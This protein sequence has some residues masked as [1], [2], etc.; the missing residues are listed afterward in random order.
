MSTGAEAGALPLA[1][2]SLPAGAAAPP[3]RRAG[4]G[5]ARLRAAGL[6]LLIPAGLG[7]VWHLATVGR[8]YSLI[9]PPAE[10]WTELRD[11]AFGGI[12]DDAFSGTL[13]AHL[14]ASLARVYG[15]F[16][17]AAAAALPLGL[18]I[19]RV[20]V[21]RALLDP[22]LQILRP[23]PVTAWLPLAMILFGLGP[24]SAY[25]LVFLGAFYPILVNTV[26]GVRSVE[27]RLFEAAAM[28]GCT[29]TAQF[30]RVVLPA[31]LP[32]IFTGLRLGLGFAWVVIVV[33]EMTGVQTGLGAIIM[34]ARQLSRTEIVICGMAVIGVAG[35]VSDWIV[36]RIG[37][38]LLAWSPSHG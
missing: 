20:P 4:P 15:G 8:P 30:A 24:R 27:P 17:L 22:T 32:S 28:L 23:I 37:R 36:M 26:F 31:A 19:G 12:N 29:G 38:S 35:F 14:A 10:V 3:A 25:F 13:W 9:P 7:L 5:L 21:V 18:L 33:G 1:A 2:G 34:E 11:L 6:A 16:A